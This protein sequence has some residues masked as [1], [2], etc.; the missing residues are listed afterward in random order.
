MRVLHTSDWQLGMTRHYLAGEA[1]ARFSE[2]RL[3]A[4]TRLG[5][6]AAAE[7]CVCVV[8]AGDVFE[9]SHPDARTVARTLE[10]LARFTVPV[11]LLPGNHDPL[12]PGSI[13]RSP[14]F[15]DRCPT[16]VEVLDG[17]EARTPVEGLEIVGAPWPS[18]QPL[19][20]L[21]AE[22]CEAAPADG[23]RRLVVGHGGV[24][25]VSGGFE[26]AGTIELSRLRRAVS[27]GRVRYVALG[28]RHSATRVDDDG[29]VWYSGAPEPTDYDEV[30]PGTALVV[31][32]GPAV[33]EVTR[34]EVGTWRFHLLRHAVDTDEDLDR[35]E[36][37][38]DALDEPSRAIVKLGLE[39]TLDLRQVARLD[40]LLEERALRFGALE[41]PQRHRDIAV[42]ATDDDVATL[43]LT[44]YA[45]V[46]RDA[47]HARATA[48]GHD[49]EVATDAL[50]L[51]LRLAGHE[52]AT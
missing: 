51:L 6:L 39:G 15:Q 16:H 33:P 13:W 9:T 20:D 19:G 26:A 31:D 49:G 21:T 18:K 29:H 8:V 45:A 17:P 36:A 44:G 43:E 7:G 5:E 3:E 37:L 1:Q 28:D 38:L 46:A 10:R 25:E 30:D 11:Y 4:V 2:A 27:D 48:G 14:I 23:A 32:L 35:L 22:A 24:A 34:H 52:E 42:R 41:H 12:D 47:L 40:A 50:S